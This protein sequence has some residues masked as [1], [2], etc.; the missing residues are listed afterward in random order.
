MQSR[1][2]LHKC[3]CTQMANKICTT[4]ITYYKV[5]MVLEYHI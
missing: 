2:N 5:E 1:N 3:V 4:N